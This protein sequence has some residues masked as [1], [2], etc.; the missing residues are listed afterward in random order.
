LKLDVRLRTPPL[1][2][3]KDSPWQSQTPSNTLEF[4]SQS[5][6]IR[7]KIH[8]HVDS[9]PTSMVEAFEKI[10]KG[11][12]VVAHKLVLSQ[13]CIAEFEAA[14]EA[15][16]RR[17]S[18]KRKRVQKERVLTVEDRVRLTTL[19]EFDAR[20]DGKKAKKRVRVKV[21]EPSQRRCRCCSEAGH[22]SRTC[23]QEAA[24]DS[25]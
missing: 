17:K 13:K 11:A 2:T 6:L 15:A 23:K 7:E 19:K 14:N 20:S 5:K 4:G 1:P 21:R 16:T 22:N 8:R 9:S 12:A 18:H 24:I 3:V 10:A 25:E